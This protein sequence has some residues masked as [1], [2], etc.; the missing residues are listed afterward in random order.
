MK[1]TTLYLLYP[2]ACAANT[3][4]PVWL[5]HSN[6]GTR[7][8]QDSR[9]SA[10]RNAINIWWNAADW[11][12]ISWR[13]WG[14]KGGWGGPDHYLFGNINYIL[15]FKGFFVLSINFEDTRPTVSTYLKTTVNGVLSNCRMKMGKLV[16]AKR[17]R[18]NQMS[19]KVH[20]IY[21]CTACDPFLDVKRENCVKLLFF[22]YRWGA[23][24][25][26][27]DSRWLEILFHWTCRI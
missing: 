25:R 19:Q 20:L 13:C 16:Q 27:C 4:R 5:L 12:G 21:L 17:K 26:C 11:W 23:S 1:Y 18:R 10:R 2:G 9:N 7:T 22:F 8:R 15:L 3:R 14:G 24:F 6:M